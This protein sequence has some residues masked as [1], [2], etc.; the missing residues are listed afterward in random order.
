MYAAMDVVEK[1]RVKYVNQH[2]G[3]FVSMLEKLI[4]SAKWWDLIDPL[5]GTVSRVIVASPNRPTH[6][7]MLKVWSNDD[8]FWVR[9]AS[10]LAHLFHKGK[11]NETLLEDT[12]KLMMYEK[13][14]FIRK[15]IGWVLREYLFIILVIAEVQRYS[16]TN[17][18]WVQ[19][20]VEKYEDQLSTLSKKEALKRIK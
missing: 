8:S 3:P 12:I 7:T 4:R 1:Y 11:T 15:A 17:P 20:F 5:S 2:E 14:F 19:E 6:E 16:K 18:E 9:R 13:E 10:L